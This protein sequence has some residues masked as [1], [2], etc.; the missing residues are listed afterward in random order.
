MG[1]SRDYKKKKTAD[2]EDGVREA[3][4]I[5]GSVQ[6]AKDADAAAPAANVSSVLL[7]PAEVDP[8][9]V[10]AEADADALEEAFFK[11]HGPKDNN[12]EKA[13]EA[14]QAQEA[15]SPSKS[16]R[17]R[18][19]TFI[20]C[21]NCKKAAASVKHSCFMSNCMEACCGPINKCS[22]SVESDEADELSYFCL[23]CWPSV[24]KSN[25]K[26]L[27]AK[28]VAGKASKFMFTTDIADLRNLSGVF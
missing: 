6:P 27:K 17:S 2:D 4:D 12:A 25:K 20:K 23:K 8:P 3:V 28:K 16:T 5:D 11:E 7:P 14:K 15:P 21:N 1:T 22:V 9:E 10:D 26:D 24:L 18:G 19:R 13:K